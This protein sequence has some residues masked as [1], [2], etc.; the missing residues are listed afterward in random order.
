MVNDREAARYRATSSP[1]FYAVCAELAGAKEG[2]PWS[3]AANGT[4]IEQ[5][6][7]LTTHN[8]VQLLVTLNLLDDMREDFPEF[9]RCCFSWV[10]AR[11][12][13][14]PADWHVAMQHIKNAA[15][16][17]RQMILY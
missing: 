8:L 7:I 3:V 10:C 4:I 9:A 11:L 17:W 16:A 14:S 15:Y 12:Q 2:S 1:G 13:V 5:G 6:Q